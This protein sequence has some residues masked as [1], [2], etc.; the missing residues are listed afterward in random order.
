MLIVKVFAQPTDAECNRLQQAS[1]PWIFHAMSDL[2][3]LH[4]LGLPLVQSR[5]GPLLL[6]PGSQ[7]MELSENGGTQMWVDFRRENK[8]ESIIKHI[9]KRYKKIFKI[10]FGD[11]DWLLETITQILIDSWQFSVYCSSFRQLQL[12]HTVAIPISIFKLVC[13]PLPLAIMWPGLTGVG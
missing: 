11:Q 7:G 8:Y 4:A 6:A 9:I 12:L 3:E 1:T 10:S 2:A 13:W 5:S